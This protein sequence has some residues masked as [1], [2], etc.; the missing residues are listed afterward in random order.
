MKLASNPQTTK[1]ADF[2]SP[3]LTFLTSAEESS[4]F[5]SERRQASRQPPGD[6][7]MVHNDL[8]AAETVW[9]LPQAQGSRLYAMWGLGKTRPGPDKGNWNSGQRDLEAVRAAS[10]GEFEDTLLGGRLS[11]WRRVRL[12]ATREMSFDLKNKVPESSPHALPHAWYIR[13]MALALSGSGT[14]IAE[15]QGLTIKD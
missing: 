1:T 5:P 2:P 10:E 7:K 9:H 4:V 12:L 11:G 8:G 6:K 3:V 14:R 15:K 13:C